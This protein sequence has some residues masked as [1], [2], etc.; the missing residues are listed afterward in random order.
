VETF[1]NYISRVAS[2]NWWEIAIELVLI[3]L[4]V[5]WVV[6]FL[7]G[8][9]GERLFRGVILILIVGV[10][11]LNLVVERYGFVRLQFLYSGFLIGILIIAV[12]GFQPEIRRVLIRLG[13]PRFW[14]SSAQRLTRTV[15]EIATAAY[16]LS[17]RKIGAIIAI[18]R[19]V[20]LGEFIETGVRIDG[21]VTAEAL[22]TIFYPGTALH[23][24]AVI[25][26]GDRILAAR[27]QLPLA[28]AGSIDGYE[29]GSRHRAAIGLTRGSDATVIVV[30]EETGTVSIAQG[31]Q[32]WRGVSESELRRHLIGH[33][34]EGPQPIISWLRR[35]KGKIN[36]VASQSTKKEQ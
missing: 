34:S 11:I 8:T 2:Y 10:L 35:R 14:S 1:I 20:A 23:D 25:I 21:K 4:V 27:A 24:M 31:G 18:E 5:Y 6:D 12:A 28:E 33:I 9:R 29:L 17:M 36:A 16:D 3:G 30:S 7:E 19:D 32:L 22:K 13:Q 26:R 15:E